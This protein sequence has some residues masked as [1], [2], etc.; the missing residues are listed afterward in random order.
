MKITDNTGQIWQI[1]KVY[2]KIENIGQPNEYYELIKDFSEEYNIIW[3]QT[4]RV[5][6]GSDSLQR[7]EIKY[8]TI[9]MMPFANIGITENEIAIEPQFQIVD[10][11]YQ[12]AGTPKSL[13][14]NYIES[15]KNFS[16]ERNRT[17]NTIIKQRDLMVER[18]EELNSATVV[19]S[20]LIAI[21][22][23]QK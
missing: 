5:L 4:I 22:C 12:I 15:V 11:G 7:T 2:L 13:Q 23:E 18:E 6:Y 10:L 19:I 17:E 14:F 21:K 8:M 20:A 1:R 9:N 3:L 16:R